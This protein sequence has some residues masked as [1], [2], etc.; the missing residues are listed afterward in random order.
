MK[1]AEQA[2]GFLKNGTGSILG[3]YL[4]WGALPLYFALTAPAHAFEVVSARVVFSLIF[5]VFLLALTHG[6]FARVISLMKSP[7]MLGILAAC[8]LLIG[9]NWTLYV[10]ATTSGHTLDASLGYF[11]N[12]LV[13]VFLGVL[14]L[15]ERLRPAQWIAVALAGISIILMSIFYGQVPWLGLG[16]AGSFGFYGLV[17]SKL[18]GKVTP[19]TSLTLETL[20]LLPLALLSMGIFFSTGTATLVSEG[21]AHFWILAASG[22]ITAVPLLLFA[23][24]ASKLPLNVIGMAQYIT[25]TLQFLIAFFIFDEPLTT[26]RLLG[27]IGIWIAC[28]IFAAS[29][30]FVL[31]KKVSSKRP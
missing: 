6:G 7:R 13:S 24:A 21:S 16:L 3:T 9:A 22:I 31:G 10:V 1:E 8:A 2:H 19:L 17:K 18:G 28:L 4:L 30:Y 20:V 5:C 15:G 23:D 26:E 25:P 29:G 12:P 11:I 14:F 27:F